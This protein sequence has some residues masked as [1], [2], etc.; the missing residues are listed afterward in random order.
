MRPRER[1]SAPS[2]LVGVLLAAAV[3]TGC[4]GADDADPAADTAADSPEPGASSSSDCAGTPGTDIRV[5][6]GQETDLPGGGGMGIGVV[7][8]EADPPRVNLVLGGARPEETDSGVGVGVGDVVTV[9]GTGYEV[10]AV[11][12]GLVTLSPAR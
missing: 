10:T 11:C 2:A 4:G 1:G 6:Q 5:L 9:K 3:L 8:M 7:D 12:A